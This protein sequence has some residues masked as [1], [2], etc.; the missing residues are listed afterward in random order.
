[1]S[2]VRGPQVAVKSLAPQWRHLSVA[3]AAQSPA[4]SA[5]CSQMNTSFAPASGVQ[6]HVQAVHQNVERPQRE[7]LLVSASPTVVLH[8]FSHHQRYRCV[9]SWL[10]TQTWPEPLPSVSHESQTCSAAPTYSRTAVTHV[11]TL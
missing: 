3:G 6:V 10:L 1:M 8:F 4:I 7:A 11:V 9:G 5:K 2:R